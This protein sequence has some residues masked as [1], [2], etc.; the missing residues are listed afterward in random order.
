ML[1]R[2]EL[3]LPVVATERLGAEDRVLQVQP[4]E[5]AGAV[6]DVVLGVVADAEREQLQQLTTVV[7]VVDVVVLVWLSS[8]KIM[9]GSLDSSTRRSRRSPRPCLRNIAIC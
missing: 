6:L 9:A 5:G 7:L 3:E 8:Q 2:A 4:G 1:V